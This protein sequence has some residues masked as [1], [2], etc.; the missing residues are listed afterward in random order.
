[1]QRDEEV[2]GEWSFKVVSPC[3][4]HSRAVLMIRWEAVLSRVAHAKA[5]RQGGPVCLPSS[6]GQHCWGK[7]LGKINN[8]Y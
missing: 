2:F 6:L 3:E 5:P 4:D 8:Q 7:V 1:M